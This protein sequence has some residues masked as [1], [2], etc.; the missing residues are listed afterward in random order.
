MAEWPVALAQPETCEALLED[1]GPLAH[2]AAQA[3]RAAVSLDLG[4]HAPLEGL[5]SAKESVSLARRGI[6]PATLLAA[7]PLPPEPRMGEDPAG[8]GGQ[9]DEEVVHRQV[10]VG[11]R[12]V[13]QC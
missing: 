2:Q 1:A 3:C 12:S 13:N 9:G 10:G 4:G 6:A 5:D 11:R 7:P 8:E